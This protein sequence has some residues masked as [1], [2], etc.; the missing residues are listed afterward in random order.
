MQE[1]KGQWGQ[2]GQRVKENGLK[3][4][5]LES[6]DWDFM[7]AITGAITFD[8]QYDLNAGREAGFHEKTDAEG[9]YQSF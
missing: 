6:T 4:G 7:S 8:G 5:A 3:D 9:V 1:R 2:W